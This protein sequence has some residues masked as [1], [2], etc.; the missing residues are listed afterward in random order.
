MARCPD[1]G[2]VVM[3]VLKVAGFNAHVLG[4]RASRIL[5]PEEKLQ[6]G[7]MCENWMKNDSSGSCR[8]V[9]YNKFIIEDVMQHVCHTHTTMFPQ[10]VS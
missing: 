7:A 4:L 5:A 6:L 1:Q 10:S 9:I 3:C 8:Q 2:E